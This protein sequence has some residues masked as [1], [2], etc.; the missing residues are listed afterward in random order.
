MDTGQE[1]GDGGETKKGE[2]VNGS[3]CP[4]AHGQEAAQCAGSPTAAAARAR[5]LVGADG[6]KREVREMRR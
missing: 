4:R 5:G 2:T 3:I 1:H 6:E